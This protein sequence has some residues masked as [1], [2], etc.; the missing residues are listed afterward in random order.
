VKWINLASNLSIL[1]NTLKLYGKRLK[2]LEKAADNYYSQTVLNQLIQEYDKRNQKDREIKIYQRMLEKEPNIYTLDNYAE[3]LIDMEKYAKA[4]EAVD[5]G[6]RIFPYSFRMMELKGKIYH[7]QHKKK[8]AL[9]WLEKSLSHNS[10]SQRLRNLIND[11][12][13]KEDPIKKFLP[14]KAYTFIKTHRE[15]KGDLKNN[16]LVIMADKTVLHVFKEGGYKIRRL[17]IYMPLTKQG[18]DILKEMNIPYRSNVAKAEIVKPGGKVVPADVSGGSVVFKNLE[19]EDVVYLDYSRIVT[20]TGRFYKDFDYDF[21]IDAF[22]PSINA[23]LYILAPKDMTIPYKVLNGK[24]SFEETSYGD[25]KVY[26]WYDRNIKKLPE[27]EDFMPDYNE[28]SRIVFVSTIGSWDEI[29]RWYRDLISSSIKYDKKVNETFAEL[30]PGGYKHL[31]EDKRAKIIYDYIADNMTYSYVDFRQSGYVPQ[32]PSKVIETKLGDCKDFSTLFLTLARKA[33]LEANIVLV[34]TNDN[35]RNAVVLPSI[36]FNHAIVK[37][38][39]DGK[40]QYLELT[41]KYLP[42]KSLPTSLFG[43]AALEIPYKETDHV[44]KGLIHLDHPAQTE[45]VLKSVVNYD[46]YPD[47]QTAK[48]HFT[49]KGRY[50]SRVLN[51]LDEKN[52]ESLKKNITD[53]TEGFDHTDLE[54]LSYKINARNRAEDLAD[55]E[56]EFKVKKEIQKLGST[57]IFKLPVMLN[58]YTN[59]LISE[60]TRHYP[61]VYPYYEDVDKYE[62]DYIIRLHGYGRFVEIPENVNL[63]YKGHYFKMTYKLVNPTTLKV[64]MESKIAFDNITPEEYVAFK[65]YVS[66]AISAMESMIGF[67]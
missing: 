23:D 19:P 42:Y 5:R 44:N 24:V 41:D 50:N 38:M 51:L 11:I 22:F 66:N 25:L 12:K 17:R 10:G 27:K 57:R 49:T 28:I 60:E 13:G 55:F 56:A 3:L 52:E 40:P 1:Y 2:F 53:F 35:G 54:L 20:K 67:K 30:F 65:K 7:H 46:I 61:I 45:T 39:I 31:P 48:V 64:H 34:S 15:L 6:L 47:K 18:V 62:S 9:E 21:G 37:V 14:E 58:P 8:E 36:G 29:A 4:M 26:H 63:H 33:D 59:K 43:A 32:R 16:D